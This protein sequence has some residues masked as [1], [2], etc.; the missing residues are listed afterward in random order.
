M[1]TIYFVR[2]GQTDWNA[3]G[4]LQGQRDIPLNA[5][6][7]RQ[8]DAVA[9][10]LAAAAGRGLTDFDFVASPLLRTRRTMEVM[11]GGLGLAEAGYRTDPRLLE[12]SFGA[13]EGS[14][15]AEIRQWD[16]AR[17]AAR[18]RN[19]WGH[20]SPGPGG[21]S[22]AMLAER[23]APAIAALTG[24]TVIVAHGGVA[25]AILVILGHLDIRE[26]PR[27]GIRQGSVL[28]LERG[29]WHWA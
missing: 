9:G 29:G 11:R 5:E 19:R 6:G 16:G 21:E 3:Q 24:P 1:T 4:R 14:T 18:D 23:V 26:A 17:A 25:R 2:H 13:W 22:Y 20:Q 10:R 28:V 7:L 15:W 12:I 27:I 8:A